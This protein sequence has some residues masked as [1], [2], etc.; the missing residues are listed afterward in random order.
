MMDSALTDLPRAAFADDGDGFTGLDGI[1]DAIHGADNAGAGAEL[2]AEVANIEE[3]R[4]GPVLNVQP[5]EA[6]C[7]SCP[8][9]GA[10][11]GVSTPR[12]VTFLDMTGP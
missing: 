7:G 9:T 10:S 6:I 1:G 8:G 11:A 3:W 12:S 4:Q 2:G 5:G